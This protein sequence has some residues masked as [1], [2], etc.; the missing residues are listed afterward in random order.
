MGFAL[1]LFQQNKTR[2][3]QTA[4]QTQDKTKQDIV[5]NTGASH[6]M[7]VKGGLAFKGVE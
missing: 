5:T 7:P 1:F 2:Q 6:R 4:S 3:N